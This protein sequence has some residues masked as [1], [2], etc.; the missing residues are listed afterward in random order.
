MLPDKAE[1]IDLNISRV[2][3]D[4]QER[5]EVRDHKKFSPLRTFHQ[6]EEGN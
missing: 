6:C 3:I 2:W 4:F 1:R 5:D